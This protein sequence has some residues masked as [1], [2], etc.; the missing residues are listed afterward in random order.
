MT[1]APRTIG[2]PPRRQARG[3][4]AIAALALLC[5]LALAGADPAAAQP[6][7]PW[8]GDPCRYFRQQRAAGRCTG[9]G[10]WK[11]NEGDSFTT[12]HADGT[13]RSNTPPPPPPPP[14]PPLPPPSPDWVPPEGFEPPRE[15]AVTAPMPAATAVGAVSP[16]PVSSGPWRGDPCGHFRRGNV[17]GRCDK[18]VW[19]Q[20]TGADRFQWFFA[21]GSSRTV[22]SA[23]AVNNSK[24]MT[25][26]IAALPP[27]VRVEATIAP[28]DPP[29][30]AW[31]GDPC[32]YFRRSNA[33]G[34][35]QNGSWRIAA[36]TGRLTLF[37]A[38]GSSRTITVQPALPATK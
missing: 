34:R 21:D 14:L 15:A 31:R 8:K 13:L 19:K 38:D 16:G 37:L 11:V 1:A 17:S 35:C 12:Y 7:G 5:G 28:P 33:V 10:N 26:T 2:R 3:R 18:G 27:A 30:G 4:Q 20:A 9:V 32:G 24:T 29:S 25:L 22:T 36:G 6:S 23:P